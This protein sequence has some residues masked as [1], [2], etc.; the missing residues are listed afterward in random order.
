MPNAALRPCNS[1]HSIVRFAGGDD[2]ARYSRGQPGPLAGGPAAAGPNAG[3]ER[4]GGHQARAARAEGGPVTAFSKSASSTCCQR[5]IAASTKA[6]ANRCALSWPFWRASFAGCRKTRRPC[7]TIGSSRP[8]I[9]G[10]AYIADLLG[11]R[12]LQDLDHIPSSAAWWLTASPTAGARDPGCSGAGDPGC[13][14]LVRAAW[15]RPAGRQNPARS[16]PAA[17]PRADG[18]CAPAPAGSRQKS[19]RIGWPAPWTWEIATRA[20][21]ARIVSASSSIACAVIRSG[22][23][24]PPPSRRTR[25]PSRLTVGRILLVQLAATGSGCFGAHPAR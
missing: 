23:C 16:L 8:A 24:L 25:A 3:G 7:T 1:L 15:N 14:G 18:R 13:D 10:G 4:P 2:L 11:V 21:T 6:R 12:R 22:G 17:G 19:R 9:A 5:S 20:D